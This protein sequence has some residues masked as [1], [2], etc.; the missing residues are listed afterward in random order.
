MS[1]ASL[2]MKEES[3]DATESKSENGEDAELAMLQNAGMESTEKAEINEWQNINMVI[4][5]QLYLRNKKAELRAVN[6][7]YFGNFGET[8]G[9]NE[10]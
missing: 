7:F 8:R 4:I 10:E 5:F 9:N 3:E 6:R 2:E 1:E